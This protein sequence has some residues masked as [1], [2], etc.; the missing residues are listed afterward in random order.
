MAVRFRITVKSNYDL[1]AAADQLKRPTQLLKD[2]GAIRQKQFD[3]MVSRQVSPSGKP[4][5]ALSPDYVVQKRKKYGG[6]PKRVASGKTVKSYR[7]RVYGNRLIE[8]IDSPIAGYL[9]NM[10]LPLLP[11]SLE[12]LPPTYKRQINEAVGDFVLKVIEQV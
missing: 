3:S 12:E 10:D 5:R 2:I 4:L 1:G 9:A 6:K 11:E 7:Q 8:T